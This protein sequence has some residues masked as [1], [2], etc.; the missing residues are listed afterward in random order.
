MEIADFR[1]Q[2]PITRS[3][4]YL[5][6]GALAPA[7]TPV[8]AAWDTWT[9]AWK[10]DPN[11]VYTDP[12]LIGSSTALR[13]SVAR[14]I[15]A[16]PTC[17]AITDNT[18]RAASIA[19]R[20]LA[21]RP[22]KNVVVDDGTYPSSVYPWYARGDRE[23]RVVATDGVADAAGALAERI[24][25]DTV[26]VCVTHVAPLTGRRHDLAAI[27]DV[28]HAHGAVVMV[29]AAQSTGVVPISVVRDG[30]DVLVTTA[31]KWLLGPPGVGFLFLAPEIL[32]DAPVLDVGYLGLNAPLGEW[33]V[34]RMP[35]VLADARRYE[36]G[37]PNLPGMF[38]ARAG[39][40][41]LLD[42]G[43]DR[44]FGR[45][46]TLATRCLDGLAERGA[47]VVTP[48]DPKQRAGVIVFN[49]VD[50]QR[51]FDRCRSDMVDVG[52]IGATAVRVDPHGFNDE[53]DIDRFLECFD[54]APS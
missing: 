2:V 40:D 38:A 54:R 37:L 28:A 21:K 17:V 53:T 16:D 27:A 43:I 18:S 11:A 8:T 29:D 13:G 44:V 9:A 35:G 34:D 30:I 19:V 10:G 1:E 15:D 32:A 12:G 24:D 25:S 46:E 41:L 49:H 6:N 22:G 23:V 45:V 52:V 5:F 26:A 33:P 14:L 50:S 7:A 47:D 4:A 31:M 36:L 3:R 48:L 20:V 42:V 51:L 39:I